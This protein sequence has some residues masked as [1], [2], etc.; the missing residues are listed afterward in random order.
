MDCKRSEELLPDYLKGS[1]NHAEE[2]QL[3]DHLEQCAACRE[4]VAIWNKLAHLPQEQPSPAMQARFQAM[5]NAYQEGRTD[6]AGAGSSRWNV[7]LAGSAGGWLRWASGF[8]CAVVLVVIGFA[9]GRYTGINEAHAKDELA[10]MRVELRSMHQLVVLSMLQQQSAGER[11][12]GI[13]WSTQQGQPDPKVLTA[14]LHTLRYDSSV[15]VRLAALNALS[16]YGNQP[17]V[18]TGVV[19]ALQPYQ[20]PLV[21]VALI[22]LLVEWRDKGAMR[23]LQQVQQDADLNPAVR[24]R[25]EWAIGKLN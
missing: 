9:V 14:L 1:L 21:Q 13:A 24:K 22:D 17:S 11:L 23:Q 5:L 19:D 4:V 6:P 18:R 2:D 20:S 8:A 10:A 7:W 3:E 15:D 12:Q 16:R 25:A